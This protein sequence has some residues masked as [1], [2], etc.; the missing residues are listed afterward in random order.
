MSL[1]R[2]LLETLSSE[3]RTKKWLVQTCRP[4]TARFPNSGVDVPEWFHR[5]GS[6]Y[7]GGGDNALQ[8]Q[9]ISDNQCPSASLQSVDRPSAL[10]GLGTLKSQLA[11]CADRSNRDVHTPPLITA[12]K[13]QREAGS[14]SAKII[15]SEDS[16]YW[17]EPHF[18]LQKNCLHNHR[19]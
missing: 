19:S 9:A 2:S 12:Q 17:W 18:F 5:N 10:H 8:R 3:N 4:H 14:E 13:A 16:S 1:F 7:L 11:S 6:V 15:Y